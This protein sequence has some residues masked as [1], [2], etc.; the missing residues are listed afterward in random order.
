MSLFS[1]VSGDMFGLFRSIN[2]NASALTAEQLRMDV[3]ANNIANV[4]T[5][6]TAE[7]TPYRRKNV[8]F[9]PKGFN[10]MEF[11]I[12]LVRKPPQTQV[13]TGVRVVDIVEDQ[14]P[15]RLVY[16]PSHPDADEKGY[17]HYPNVNIVTEM[18][19]LI[20]ASRS[21]E[22]NVTAI[23]SAK[24]MFLKAIDIVK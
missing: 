14:S 12:P 7:G 2:T 4:N 1:V 11:Y 13:G 24:N 9:E 22:A 19:D 15:L 18:V 5:T 20:T 23:K 6:R 8:V 21:Y 16:D 17:V 10:G 3:I